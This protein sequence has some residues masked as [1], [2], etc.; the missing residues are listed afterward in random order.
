MAKRPAGK[1]KQRKKTAPNPR[2]NGSE[3]DRTVEFF[4]IAWM[5]S[6]FTTLV[7]EL[8]AVAA[9]WYLR[10]HPQ[11]V[12]IEVLA[13]ILVFASL[14]IGMLSLVLMA[15]V[16]RFRSTRP[17]HGISVFALVVGAAPGLLLL[18]RNVLW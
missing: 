5:L 14:V 7:C 12:R 13:S 4:T 16:F 6:V 8:S 18:L 11:A 1:R 10:S 15:V 3:E 9:T 2:W 17:P